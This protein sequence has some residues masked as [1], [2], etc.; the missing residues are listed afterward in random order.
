MAIDFSLSE[1]QVKLQA[2]TRDFAQR[3]LT[4]VKAAIANIARPEDRFYAIRPFY[5]KMVEAGFTRALIPRQSSAAQACRQSILR[6]PPRNSPT[7]DINV[8]SALLATGLGLEPI[9]RYGSAEQ[10]REFLTPYLATNGARLA[11]LAFTEVTGGA[12]FDTPDPRFGVRTFARRDGDH[13]VISGQKHYTTNGTG[14]DGKGA[15]LFTVVCRT[16]PDKPPQESLA[17]IV[18]PGD[19]PGNRD[20]RE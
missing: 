7:V 9:I 12:N 18:V 10:K 2:D 3:V 13:W 4:G 19:S 20:C 16:D 6:S 1:S 15:D 17:I 5:E 8:P 11:A 14:W